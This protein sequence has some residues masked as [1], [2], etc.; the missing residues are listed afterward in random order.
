VVLLCAFIELCLIK[1]SA[2][3]TFIGD[4]DRYFENGNE[5]SREALANFA[6]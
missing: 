5:I 2:N 6:E 4:A 3:F 1:H